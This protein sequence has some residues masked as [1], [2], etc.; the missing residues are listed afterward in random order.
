MTTDTRTDRERELRALLADHI[1]N[2][3]TLVA[4]EHVGPTTVNG[5]ILRAVVVY[6][7]PTADGIRPPYPRP[8]AAAAEH[9]Q[10]G[11]QLA[12]FALLARLTDGYPGTPSMDELDTVQDLVAFLPVVYET[13]VRAVKGRVSHAAR[14]V[15]EDQEVV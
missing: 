13:T 3:A 8:I 10:Q 2:G 9:F 5:N 6:A 1:E 11:R 14:A 15:R 12:T 7:I 4:T